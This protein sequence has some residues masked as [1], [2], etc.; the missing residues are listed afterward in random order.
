MSLFT[1]D[2]AEAGR[3]AWCVVPEAAEAT[4]TV[5]MTAAVAAPAPMAS[6]SV[7]RMICLLYWNIR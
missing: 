1:A 7:L 5:M 3:A 4:P 2:T 6:L